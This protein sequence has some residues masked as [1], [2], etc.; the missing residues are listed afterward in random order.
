MLKKSLRISADIGIIFSSY[1]KFKFSQRF[2]ILK[3]VFHFF[4][5]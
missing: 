5:P 3:A 1:T 4:L 2:L